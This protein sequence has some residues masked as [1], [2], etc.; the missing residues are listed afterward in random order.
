MQEKIFQ[1]NVSRDN[2]EKLKNDNCIPSFCGVRVWPSA[3]YLVPT[4]HAMKPSAAYLVPT[5]HAMKP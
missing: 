5:Y 2:H 1:A 3:A 4:Y